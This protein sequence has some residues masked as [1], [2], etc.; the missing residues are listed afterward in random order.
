MT[1]LEFPVTIP[2]DASKSTHPD[3]TPSKFSIKLDSE[4]NLNGDWEVS[5]I[6]LQYPH[7]W[8]N[9]QKAS[10]IH[11]I[12]GS[13]ITLNPELPEKKY[14]D[15][16][17]FQ[18]HKISAPNLGKVQQYLAS[19]HIPISRHRRVWIDSTYFPSLQKLGGFICDEI[20]KEY[21]EHKDIAANPLTFQYDS[22]QN[23]VMFTS[24][25]L[26]YTI[27]F[28]NPEILECLGYPL[29]KDP[30][31]ELYILP[32][33]VFADNAPKLELINV[34]YVYSSILKYQIVGDVL[35]PL[36]GVFP[37]QSQRGTLGYWAFSPRYY[38]PLAKSQLSNIDIEL[39]SHSGELIN[40]PKGN[41][42]CRLHFRRK[43]V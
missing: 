19:H 29:N 40:F 5:I 25:S 26:F 6:D 32:I 30:I 8:T 20:N 11:I 7:N 1:S 17:K 14:D 39:R 22:M 9:I 43:L 42:V 35:A 38:V 24:V 4:I 33:G 34:I 37:V 31:S 13:T 16:R 12:Y 36:L 3:N 18:P 27:Q 41:T 15:I 21:K 23:R 28:E 10:P 2:S